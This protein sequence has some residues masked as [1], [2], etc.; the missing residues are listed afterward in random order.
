MKQ[1]LAV[2][3]GSS[4]L[5]IGIF[6]GADLQPLAVES[7]KCSE[8]GTVVDLVEPL[9]AQLLV[10]SGLALE[11]IEAVGH[12]IVH[13]GALCATS[14][15]DAETAAK[16]DAA[17]ALAPLHNPPAL[18]V[19]RELSARMP[20]RP[21]VCVFDTTFFSALQPSEKVLPL[22]YEWFAD[23]GIRRFGFHGISHAH[24]AER[25]AALCPPHSGSLT[26]ISFHLGSGCSATATVNG[27][28]VATTMGYTPMDGLVMGTRPGALDPG[29]LVALL[30]EGRLSLEQLED[31]LLHRSG[32]RGVSGTTSDYRTLTK[33]ASEGDERAALALAM[34]TNSAREQLGAYLARLGGADAIVFSGGIGEHSAAARAAICGGL[35]PLGVQL[36][37]NAN[38]IGT[39]EFSFSPAGARPRL[40]VVPAEEERFVAKETVSLLS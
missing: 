16:L 15:F 21:Q 19:L 29:V 3:A 6:T 33:Q 35:E 37:P 22:P 38:E 34:F 11:D 4:S 10:K 18:K 14:L 40:L 9:L 23:W 2:N 31:A 30:R 26:V 12:R 8:S 28:A 7:A 17:A 20:G 13:G 25:A 32:L 27:T 36:D 39:G 5:K 1:V 24:M